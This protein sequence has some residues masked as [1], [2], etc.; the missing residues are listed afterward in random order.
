MVRKY[1][2]LIP[3]LLLALLAGSL[4]AGCSEERTFT[5]EEFVE[6]VNAQG[7]EM[8]LGEELSTTESGA[9]LH[10]VE[11]EPLVG[12][13]AIPG[14]GPPGGSL[15]VYDDTADAEDRLDEC[16]AAADLL[17]YQAANV[18]VILEQGGIEAQRLGVAIQ[19]LA[20]E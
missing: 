16:K 15:A 13:P 10:A 14:E 11:L 9:E 19:K 5:A 12:A 7:V 20:E 8:H 4:A 1:A 18:V 3:L 6:E 17:C 2:A